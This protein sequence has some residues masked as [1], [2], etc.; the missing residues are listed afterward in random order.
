MRQATNT[1]E[2]EG[3]LSEVDINEGSY[4]GQEVLRG[5]ITIK[6]ETK[7][8]GEE[9]TVEIPVNVY[10][11]KYKRDGKPNPAY[12]SIK[13][14]RDEY[15]SIAAVGEENATLIRITSGSISMNEFYSNRTGGLISYPRIRGSFFQTV[16]RTEYD[17]DARFTVEMVIRA[18]TEEVDLEGTPT[19]RYKLIGIIPQ[20]GGKLDVVPFFI[21]NPNVIDV[22]TNAWQVG[23]SVT[24]I[25]KLN[26]SSRVEKV[27]ESI[28]G[29][30]G[31]DTDRERTR[32]IN[33]SELVIGG[34]AEAPLTDERAW[35]MEEIK[36]ALTER[37]QR[38]ENQKAS[39]TMKPRTTTA[40]APATSKSSAFDDLGF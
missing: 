39:S 40:P 2:I 8:N 4:N 12:E 16:K 25:G 7:I 5:N 19:G 32:T 10:A 1:V 18:I 24:A 21:E 36:E 14:V 20:Y 29:G 15:K 35:D 27:H 26:F 30:F 9:K 28:E 17:P 31:E 37:Q 6:S 23:D 34:G 38:L 22:I 3:I 11:T 33:V 13:R